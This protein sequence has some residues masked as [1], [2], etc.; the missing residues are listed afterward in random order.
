M[1]VFDK[2]ILN[3]AQLYLSKKC[4]SVAHYLVLPRDYFFNYIFF[5]FSEFDQLEFNRSRMIEYNRISL[6]FLAFCSG[7]YEDALNEWIVHL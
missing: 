1:T 3:I 4:V 2:I 7:L 5:V 6:H